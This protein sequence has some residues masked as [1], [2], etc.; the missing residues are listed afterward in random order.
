MNWTPIGPSVVANGQ[1][2][3]GPP[4][5]GRITTLA[6]GP[7]GTRLYAG[8]ANGGVWHSGDSGSSWSPLDDYFETGTPAGVDADSLSVGAIGIQF[9]TSPTQDLV[10]IGT[11]EPNRNADAYFGVGIRRFGPPAG[12]GAPAW[13]LEATNLA[14]AGIYQPWSRSPK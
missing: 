4:V 5:A 6:I 12:G 14:G 13:T 9:G 10:Y 1:A 11:G 2:V 3:G 7:G 8:S